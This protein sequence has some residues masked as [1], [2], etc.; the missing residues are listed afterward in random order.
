MSMEDLNNTIY[1]MC[2]LWDTKPPLPGENDPVFSDI[3]TLIFAGRYDST[4]PPSFAHQLAEHLTHS[5]IAE[6]PNQGHAPSASA[7]S[8]CPATLISAFMQNPDTAPALTCVQETLQIQFIVPFNPSTPIELEPVLMEEYQ[9]NTR[10]PLDWDKAN[11]GFYNR[12]GFWGDI[13]QIGIQRAPVPESDWIQWLTGNFGGGQGLDQP[14]VKQSERVANGLTWSLY[15]TS[16][17]GC[18]VEIA[19]ASSSNQ[20]LMI[21]MVSY[22]DE[23]DAFFDKVFLP[24]IDS[25]IPLR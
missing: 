14:A 15:K 24:V 8:N 18:P 22:Q 5:Y 11:F 9:I 7:L 1:D 19:L 20:T 12:D 10:I 13:T 21:L 23:H 6:I 3:P 16:S 2:E 25:T 4:T 17:H